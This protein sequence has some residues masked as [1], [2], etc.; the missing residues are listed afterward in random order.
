MVGVVF[1]GRC[2][3]VEP[4]YGLYIK[5]FPSLRHIYFNAGEPPYNLERLLLALNA[6]YSVM[7]V[8]YSEK[9][10]VT[11]RRNSSVESSRLR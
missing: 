11:V 3:V 6:R 8:G 4:G 9:R 2:V 10:G 1:V 7:L 5:R